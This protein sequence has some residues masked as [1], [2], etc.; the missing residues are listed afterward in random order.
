MSEDYEKKEV[1]AKEKHS[2]ENNVEEHFEDLS[3][4]EMAELQGQGTEAQGRS[5]SAVVDMLL[6]KGNYNC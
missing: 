4:A 2:V 3:E 5:I 1:K 6:S